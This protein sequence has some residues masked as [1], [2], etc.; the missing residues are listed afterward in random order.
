MKGL[1]AS[2]N[3]WLIIALDTHLTDALVQEGIAR[4]FVNKINTMRRE[5]GLDVVDRI[6]V[7]I[8]TSDAIRS[9]F[10]LHH[11]YI[12]SEVL[13]SSVVS[14]RQPKEP[15]G[16]STRRKRLPFKSPKCL[17]W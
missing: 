12:A 3:G 5:A 10:D 15:P 16:L 11:D 6:H 8:D 9:A 1:I 13:A 17:N 4:E 2:T 14:A 7:V